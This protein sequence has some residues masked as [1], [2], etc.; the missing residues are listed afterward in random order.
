MTTLWLPLT[1]LSAFSLATSDALTKRALTGRNEYLVAWLRL[2]PALPIF[3][4]PLPFLHIPPLGRDFF[5]TIALALPLEALALVLYVKAL[6]LSPLSLTLPFL[7]LTPLL[8]LV[9]P[10]LLLGERLTATGVLGIVLVA[11][12]S[13]LLNAGRAREGLIA[14]IRA[15][16]TEKGS[17]CMVAV[18]AI[19][20]V[21]SVLGKRAIALSSPLVFTSCYLPLLVIL[22]TPIALYKGRAEL[23]LI[24]RNGTLRATALPALFYAL[25]AAA[26]VFALD[27]TNV[28]YMIAVKRTSLIFG[29]LYGRYL[30]HEKGRLAA[31]S[32]MLAGVFLIVAGG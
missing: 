15:L 10:T 6:K 8:L 25:Q 1:L 5:A 14:P 18:A 31:A 13:Y 17:F 3:L 16:L 21:T 4:A 29:V 19:Y 24:A 23:G 27:L 2:L 7:A 11:L 32:L 28:A 9:L 26:H 12:G 20:S 22:F 30:F